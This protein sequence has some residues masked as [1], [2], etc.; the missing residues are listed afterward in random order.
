VQDPP[1]FTQIGIFGLKI[2]H[3]ATLLA[4]L[5]IKQ[6]L[7]TADQASRRG[8]AGD[9]ADVLQPLGPCQA[10]RGRAR[11]PKLAL[12]GRR[13]RHHHVSRRQAGSYEIVG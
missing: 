7:E 11:L 2:Y 13:G 12:V 1:I 5:L 10:P 3:L 6:L 4:P 8:E 9:D